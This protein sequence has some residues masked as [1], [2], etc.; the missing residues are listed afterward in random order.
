[1]AKLAAVPTTLDV[2]I[3]SRLS[4]RPGGSGP[5]DRGPRSASV[6]KIPL[7]SEVATYP[8]GRQRVE[9]VRTASARRRG[10]GPGVGMRDARDPH[11][12]PF[13]RLDSRQAVLDHEALLRAE[14]REVPTG[15]RR[16]RRAPGD[17]PRGR[18]CSGGVLGGDDD[19]DV[20]AAVQPIQRPFDFRPQRPRIDR[21]GPPLGQ[22][23]QALGRA[24]EEAEAGLGN[25]LVTR[26]L[27]RRGRPTARGPPPARPRGARPRSTSDRRTPESA[28]GI[29]FAPGATPSSARTSRKSSKWTRSSS[30]STPLKSRIT[31][32]IM[33]QRHRSR[34][35]RWRH[36]HRSAQM[37]S[38][39]LA[40]PDPDT[41]LHGED[42]DLAVTASTTLR[43]YRREKRGGVLAEGWPAIRTPATTWSKANLRL[44]VNIAAATWARGSASR[45]SSRR[46]TSD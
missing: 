6:S 24:G 33:P 46:G 45:T 13:R 37:A 31:A 44:V 22:A 19:R 18:A 15:D 20:L 42:E 28:R 25:P 1:M 4:N 8:G 7:R 36:D 27:A 23:G 35:R 3:R 9:A 11:A 2:K 5:A 30:T 10:A 32:R 17:S 16:K 34:P 39:P 14:G 29:A 40:G 38:G 41:V 21:Q 26:G 43:C 12:G